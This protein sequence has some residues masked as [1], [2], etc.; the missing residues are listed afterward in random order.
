MNGD[1]PSRRQIEE[2][3]RARLVDAQR[4]YSRAKRE[5]ENAAGVYSRH[6]I[7]FPD[8]HLGLN[9][10]LQRERIA[11]KAYTQALRIVTDI[12]VHGKLPSDLAVD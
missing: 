9:K 2:L 10:A 11:F 1:K 4:R 5:S 6:E 7:P 12:T 8:G 3:W